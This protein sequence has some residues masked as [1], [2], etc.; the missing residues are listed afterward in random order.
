MSLAKPSLIF[1]FS[2]NSTRF[3]YSPFFSTSRIY[4]MTIALCPLLVCLQ[5][6]MISS[7]TLCSYSYFNSS[8]ML[9]VLQTN[10]ITGLGADLTFLLIPLK[11]YPMPT[12]VLYAWSKN[13]WLTISTMGAFTVPIWWLCIHHLSDIV[14]PQSILI[15]SMNESE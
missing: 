1:S 5:R 10:L 9:R 2:S 15:E 12:T 6:A 14:D 11:S 13:N 7:E 8:Y 3:N 4:Y